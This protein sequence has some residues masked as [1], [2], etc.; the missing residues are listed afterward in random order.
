MSDF[1]PALP[2]VVKWSVGDNRYNEDG[3]SPKSLSLFV[4]IESIQALAEYLISLGDDASKIK[5][6][7]IWD[8]SAQAEVEV[9][10]VYIN[11]KGRDGRDGGAYGNINPAA[12]SPA[13][14]SF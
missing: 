6:G 5:S 7:K 11:A 12:I 9:Q 8:Y 10:G 14:L 2:K 4:P 1:N 13:E 3:K